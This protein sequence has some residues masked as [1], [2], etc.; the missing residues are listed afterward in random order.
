MTDLVRVAAEVAPRGFAVDVSVRQGERVAVVGPNGSGKST[1]LQLVAGSL[2]PTSGEV[3]IGGALVS[4]PRLHVPAHR[5][6][7][8]YVEQRPLLF[9]H[10]SVLENVM[11]GPLARGV[12]RGTARQRALAELA[13]T[14]C[15][16]LAD[17]R[18]A[19]LSGGQAQRVSLARS[20]AI[21]PALV[22]LDEPFAALDVS[23]SP[24]LRRLL[25]SRLAD[26]TTILVSHE[27]LDVVTLAD[28]LVLIEDGRILA[29]GGVEAM[30][31]AP[32]SRFLA[33]FVGL[34]LLHGTVRGP[35]RLDLGGQVLVGLSDA[36]LVA[37]EHARATVAPDGISLH[38]RPPEGSPR[39]AL[40]A[41]VTA[42]EPRGPVVG[43]GLEL[44]GQRLRADLTPAAVAELG[45]ALGDSV[46]AAMKATQVRLHPTPYDAQGPDRPKRS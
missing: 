15:S 27:L 6:T 1:L 37:G 14:G 46:V 45:L 36:D 12:D 9:P 19:R 21:D 10:L 35:D 41:I 4:S 18:P 20:L 28:R 22:L 17:R 3:R 2:R 30:C 31:E 23:V 5:R 25:R 16:E 7:I 13:A 29:D 33:D 11:F 24:E 43:V 38:H 8:A 26:M 42:I 44:A 32:V 34:N 39:N 40:A